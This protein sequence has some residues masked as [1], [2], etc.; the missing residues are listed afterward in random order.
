MVKKYN[1]KLTNYPLKTGWHMIQYFQETKN[2]FR[3]QINNL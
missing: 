2:F 1:K 3:L